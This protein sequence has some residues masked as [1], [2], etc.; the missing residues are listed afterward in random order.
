MALVQFSIILDTFLRMLWQSRRP[1][2][3][4]NPFS[5]VNSASNFVGRIPQMSA[6]EMGYYGGCISEQAVGC[7]LLSKGTGLMNDA[8][9]A[10]REGTL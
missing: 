5:L 9:G 10:A 6:L 2:P 3:S 1:S 4:G 7:L 8:I